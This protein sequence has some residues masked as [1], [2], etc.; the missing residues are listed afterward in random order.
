MATTEAL[1]AQDRC[2]GCGAAAIKRVELSSGFELL[3]CN[4]HYKKSEEKLTSQEA[5]VTFDA[6]KT[7][8]LEEAALV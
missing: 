1:T 7:E 8:Q 2:D 4:H 3:F 6:D 5:R